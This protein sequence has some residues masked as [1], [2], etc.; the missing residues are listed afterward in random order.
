MTKKLAK[1]IHDRLQRVGKR[2]GLASAQ[3]QVVQTGPAETVEQ[4]LARGGCVQQFPG[5]A[6]RLRYYQEQT[7]IAER[8]AGTAEHIALPEVTS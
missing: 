7:E 1:N 5:D 3:K 4:F 2:A 8:A 6:R